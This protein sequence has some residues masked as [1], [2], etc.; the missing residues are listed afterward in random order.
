MSK[1]A[2]LGR[3][4]ALSGLATV[5]LGLLPAAALESLPGKLNA[6][7]VRSLKAVGVA[8]A[9]PSY[10]PKNFQ[11][12]QLA[13]TPCPPNAK[14]DAKGNCTT[15]SGYKMLYR[16]PNQTC[17]EIYGEYTRGIGG[18]VGEFA[19]P[20]VTKL[21]G[22]IWVGFGKGEGKDVYAEK[23]PS[24]QQLTLPQAN[25][26]SFPVYLPGTAIIYGIRTVDKGNGCG[27]NRSLTPL[28]TK[29]ILQSLLWLPG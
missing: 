16:N 23:E 6:V 20:I 7:Q 21:F 2:D 13:T 11:L 10:I 8:V 25:L 4:I 27:L 19:F 24:L 22:Q 29:N 28:E 14:K 26:T 15:R 12:V 5:S 17:F 1:K 18:G 3:A 9:V